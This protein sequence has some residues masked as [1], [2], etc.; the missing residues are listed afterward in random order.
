MVKVTNTTSK[1][2]SRRHPSGIVFHWSPGETKDIESKR[3]IEEISRQSC[4]KIGEEVG[5]KDVG[6][7]L[8]THVRTPKR[9]GRP[10]KSK[11]KKEVKSKVQDKVDKALKKPKGLKKSKKGD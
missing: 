1:V 11:S 8:K 2:L 6:G 4:W 3:L 9:R 7:G 5:K 10:S